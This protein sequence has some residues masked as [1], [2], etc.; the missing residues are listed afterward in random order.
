VVSGT[1]SMAAAEV[2][3][4]VAAALGAPP[5]ALPPRRAFTPLPRVLNP[6]PLP[7]FVI[8]VA[9]GSTS[10]WLSSNSSCPSLS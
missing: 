8:A 5:R 1:G 6:F 10:I 7:R 2:V 9:G 3:V 4:A